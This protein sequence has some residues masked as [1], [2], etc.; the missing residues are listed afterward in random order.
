MKK[1]A[2]IT[3]EKREIWVI[4]EGAI[5]RETTDQP[6]AEASNDVDESLTATDQDDSDK[7]LT[8]EPE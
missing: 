7:P 8:E 2:V 6:Q 4:S 3:T 5:T 1:G